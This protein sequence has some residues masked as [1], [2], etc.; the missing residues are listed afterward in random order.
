[1]VVESEETT[2]PTPTMATVKQNRDRTNTGTDQRMG[3]SKQYT[4]PALKIRASS[5][6]RTMPGTDFPIRISP[7]EKCATSSWSKV[8]N[9]LSRATLD[10]V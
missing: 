6:P 4:A 2:S 5:I 9:S 8:P 1:M 3:M 7:G 10:V